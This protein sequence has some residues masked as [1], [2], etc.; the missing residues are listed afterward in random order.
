MNKYRI[1]SDIL[2]GITIGGIIGF[3]FVGKLAIYSTLF[4]Y[5]IIT[6]VTI[7]ELYLDER[8]EKK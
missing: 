6:F 7:I 4:L 5:L 1:L 3:L 2:I 8:K